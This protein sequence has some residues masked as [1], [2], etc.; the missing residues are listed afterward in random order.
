MSRFYNSRK[1][2]KRTKRLTS[3]Y[4]F[5]HIRYKFIQNYVSRQDHSQKGGGVVLSGNRVMRVGQ[6]VSFDLILLTNFETE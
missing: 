5:K 3:L 1:R 6:D 4:V 2:N